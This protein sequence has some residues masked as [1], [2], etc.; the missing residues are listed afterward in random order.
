MYSLKTVVTKV[1]AILDCI[2]TAKRA[3]CAEK[4]LV[5]QIFTTF[6]LTC[7]QAVFNGSLCVC[8]GKAQES[9]HINGCGIIIVTCVICLYCTVGSA[10]TDS[11]FT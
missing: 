6:K 7:K 8:V 11:N 2:S 1:I 3:K 9:A 5:G 10:V 4:C